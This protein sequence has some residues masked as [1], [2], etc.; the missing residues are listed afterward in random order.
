MYRKVKESKGKYRKNLDCSGKYGRF[1]EYV[2]QESGKE[3]VQKDTL[4]KEGK[5]SRS[6]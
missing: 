5:S 3:F 4:W 6:L 2:A 1:H